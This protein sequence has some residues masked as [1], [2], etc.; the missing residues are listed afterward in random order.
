MYL[1]FMIVMNIFVYTHP[2]SSRIWS[3]TILLVNNI[4]C[5]K[6]W[7]STAVSSKIRTN[8]LMWSLRNALTSCFSCLCLFRSDHEWYIITNRY[9][10]ERARLIT[11]R[12]DDMSILRI[13]SQI[14]LILRIIYFLYLILRI[15]YRNQPS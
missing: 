2:L 7:I 12:C 11:I 9:N 4:L 13:P 8:H 3:F 5:S 14:L 15:V 6:M 10:F 1:W